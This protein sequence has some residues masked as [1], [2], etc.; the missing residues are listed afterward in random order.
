VPLQQFVCDSVTLIA[1]LHL[2][3]MFFISFSSSADLV[4]AQAGKVTAGLASH[5]S[6]T[7][8]IYPPTGSHIIERQMSTPHT[9]QSEYG[10]F[11]FTVLFL[12]AVAGL[13]VRIPAATD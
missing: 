10:H 4:S 2:I 8:A 3:F 13:T 1:V 7:I 12:L 11:T 5:A 6:Q 9:L